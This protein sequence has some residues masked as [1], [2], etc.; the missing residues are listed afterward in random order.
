MVSDASDR[1][2]SAHEV[3]PKPRSK[4]SAKNRT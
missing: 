2:P 4:K 1:D 3:L